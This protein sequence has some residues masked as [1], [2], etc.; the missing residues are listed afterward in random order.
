MPKQVVKIDPEYSNGAY[1]GLDKNFARFASSRVALLPIPYDGTST[2]QKGAQLGPA[3]LLTASA[4]MELYDIET[5]SA[6]YRQGLVT[7][8]PVNCPRD[9]A[10]MVKVVASTASPLLRDKKFV[11]GLGGEHSISVGLVQA[12]KHYYPGLTVLQLDAHSDLRPIYEQSPYNHACVMARIRELC[13]IYQVGI[14]SMDSVELPFID[15]QRVLYAHEWH[16]NPASVE[17]IIA[18]LSGEIYITI[19]LDVFDPAM[20]PSTGTPEPG[21]LDWY[22]VNQFLQ[23]VVAQA[24]VVGF[25]VVELLPNPHDRAPDFLAAKLVYRLLSMI[26][27][28]EDQGDGKK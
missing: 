9:P 3:A 5:S 20:F 6:V 12:Y 10:E 14:R 25:D 17:K 27:A 11:I 2:W 13:P 1:G 28:K 23:A 24:N 7:L 16:R 15:D 21:G 4:N 18:A 22:T 8:P 26:F 19:D